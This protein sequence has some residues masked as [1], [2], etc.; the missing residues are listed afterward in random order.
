MWF[1]G[2]VCL[3][4][5]TPPSLF[6][7][8]LEKF[9]FLRSSSGGKALRLKNPRKQAYSVTPTPS[10]VEAGCARTALRGF[11]LGRHLDG[12]PNLVGI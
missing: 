5:N 7:M 10:P 2:I 3:N 4:Y 12:S 9:F 6:H 11:L 8:H 1:Y